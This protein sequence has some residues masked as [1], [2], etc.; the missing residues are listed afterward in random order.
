MCTIYNLMRPI[1]MSTNVMKR[2]LVMNRIGVILLGLLQILKVYV[3]DVNSC[4]RMSFT[5]D[6]DVAGEQ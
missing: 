1:L 3:M 2:C 6:T 4:I 5:R